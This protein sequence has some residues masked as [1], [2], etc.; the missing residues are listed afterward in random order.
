MLCIISD[1][2]VSTSYRKG[3]VLKV[4]IKDEMRLAYILAGTQELKLSATLGSDS[5]ISMKT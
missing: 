4:N 1:L 3:E 5:H 2:P